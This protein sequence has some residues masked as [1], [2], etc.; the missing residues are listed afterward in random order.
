[1]RLHS[2]WQSYAHDAER[3]AITRAGRA[4]LP[5]IIR[6]VDQIMADAKRDMHFIQFGISPFDHD[7]DHPARKRHFDWFK[8]HGLRWETV[9]P[10][11]WLEGDPG[12]YAV[13]FD[14]PDDPRIAAYAAEF[15]DDTGKSH[16]PETYQLYLLDYA[17]WFE[18][19]GADGGE[20][21]LDES[22]DP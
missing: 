15:E 9:A 2:S 10:R 13:H 5:K 19:H 17:S 6:S 8:A 11:G 22:A 1:M 16:D 4:A 14:G 3:A 18:K 21:W 12:I 20:D 7:P